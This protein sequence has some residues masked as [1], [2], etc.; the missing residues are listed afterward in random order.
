MQQ[1]EYIL[2]IEKRNVLRSYLRDDI[3]V[4]C[5]IDGTRPR[6][7][8]GIGDLEYICAAANWSGDLFSYPSPDCYVTSDLTFDMC[9]NFS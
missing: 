8:Q 7:A 4:N 6:N 1:T 5:V 2:D 9:I 3:V